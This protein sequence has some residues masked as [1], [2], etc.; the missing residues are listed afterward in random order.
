V[1]GSTNEILLFSFDGRLVRTYGRTG[2]G[3][4]E[5]RN[6]GWVGRSDD[7]LFVFDFA[8]RRISTIAND[9][10][11][12]LVRSTLLTAQGGRG[13]VFVGGRLLNGS[14]LVLTAATPGW[15]G[16]PG[17]HRLPASAG[18]VSAAG[19][20]QVTWLAQ[21]PGLAVVVYNPTGNIRQAVVGPI[22]FSP[23]FEAAARGHF[24]WFAESGADSLERFD[25][26][27]AERRVIRL[28]F[29]PARPAPAL[30]EAARAREENT[31][32]D[33]RSREWTK[34]KYS[35]K[36][37]PKQLPRFE[38]L[39]PGPS[40]ELWVQQY[41]GIR[42][43]SARYL[44]LDAELRPVAWVRVASGFRAQDVGVDYVLGVHE[45]DDGVETIQ[46]F[47]LTRH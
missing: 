39:L 3:P 19:D 23:D 40:G 13:L 29:P 41:S 12:H 11:P 14:W 15:D 24:V 31:A 2:A 28:P 20:G 5:F 25:T 21:R 8:S 18:L 10:N 22:A 27:T 9:S 36:Y 44:V 42:S 43:N 47:R 16:P 1:S 7:T 37:L 6:V 32:R 38:A 33:A 34:A 35:A 46:M 17:V 30:V 26:R 45:D 4:A